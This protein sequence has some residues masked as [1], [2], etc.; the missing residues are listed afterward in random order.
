MQQMTS[1]TMSDFANINKLFGRSLTCA[2]LVTKASE[3]ISK[4]GSPY[5]RFTVEDF[6]G[7]HEFTM[8]G[9]DY[10]TFKGFFEE[11][12]PLRLHVVVQ[13]RRSPYGNA[14][15]Q[16]GNSATKELEVRVNK[17]E[18]LRDVME[19]GVK[20]IVANI[21]LS[22]VTELFI[23]EL[24]EVIIAAPKGKTKF[25]LKVFDTKHGV[26]VE[27]FSRSYL[28]TLTKELERFFAENEIN[29]SLI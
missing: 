14:P 27:L 18:L 2:G 3:F 17:V 24:T 26:S 4:K 11:G 6:S 9:A 20:K 15:Q 13:E 1:C 8:F 29:F 5:G 28:I 23:T 10:V 22:E 7:S 19:K 12:Y 21:D 16:S 25:Y